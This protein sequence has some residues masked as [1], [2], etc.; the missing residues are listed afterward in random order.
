VQ[1]AL[2]LIGGDR[3]EDPDASTVPSANGSQLCRS[4]LLL[5]NL[6]K[7]DGSLLALLQDHPALEGL[8]IPTLKEL[9]KS[10]Q[11]Q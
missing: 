4:V 9:R 7:Q 3:L 6:V 5:C 8:D 10:Q 2:D 1:G 11:S